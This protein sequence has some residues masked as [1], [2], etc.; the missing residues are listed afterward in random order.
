MATSKKNTDNRIET[1]RGLAILGVVLHHANLRMINALIEC[2][3]DPGYISNIMSMC[4]EFFAPLRMP[5]FTIIS[6][7]VYAIR[8]VNFS[9]LRVF[10][11]GKVR[12]IILPLFFLSTAFY[13]AIGY[14]TN[15]FPG[16]VGKN[17]QAV[18]PHEFW[19]LWF[20]HFGHLWFL[21]ALTLIFIFVAFV[22]SWGLMDDMKKWIF[23]V[24]A[25]S[26]AVYIIPRHIEF[27]SINRMRNIIPFFFFGVGLYRFRE[28]I[29]SSRYLIL[30]AIP[31]LAASL[32]IDYFK[33]PWLI[34]RH[35]WPLALLIGMI[36]PVALLSLNFKCKPLIW[37]GKY[38]YTI[39]LWHGFAWYF[40]MTIGLKL[41]AAGYQWAFALMF[42]ITG[43]LFP[44]LIE[45][46]GIKI[47]LLRTFVLGK[48]P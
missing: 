32:L 45:K 13:F 34:A 33:W 17:P 39:Y 37:I 21:Q 30:L 9:N 25:T 42:L 4:S 27:F 43:L 12:R 5:L 28:Q 23:W 29:F 36:A 22:D 16:I 26:L 24:I 20:F 18:L 38:S 10:F 31:I 2:N 48:K 35:Y 47:P 14:T 40:L 15:E 19:K 1:L 11:A 7:W 46:T 3:V 8:P 6:G 41:I 44:V